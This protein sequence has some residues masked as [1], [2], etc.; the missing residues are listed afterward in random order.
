MLTLSKNYRKVLTASFCLAVLVGLGIPYFGFG[1]ANTAGAADSSMM[2][3]SADSVSS[4]SYRYTQFSLREA[5]PFYITASFMVAGGLSLYA[6]SYI[7]SRAERRSTYASRF[8][9]WAR[10]T[11]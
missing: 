9:T 5:Y 3:V 4:T 10:T 7:P 11:Y 8:E 2:G 6:M 1:A